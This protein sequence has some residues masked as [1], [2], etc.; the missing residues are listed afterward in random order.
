MLRKNKRP[1]G[2]EEGRALSG[3]HRGPSSPPLPCRRPALDWPHRDS[4]GGHSS[5][6]QPVRVPWTSPQPTDGRDGSINTPA[7]LF[8][9]WCDSE[10]GPSVAPGA[11]QWDRGLV[12]HRG[13]RPPTP[14]YWLLCMPCSTPFSLADAPSNPFPNPCLRFCFWG[15]KLKNHPLS[16][17]CGRKI[18]RHINYRFVLTLMNKLASLG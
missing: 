12:A 9:G 11:S 17:V 15:S 3:L 13:D 14:L 4:A 5:C 8:F 16:V 10:A 7:P 18:Y 1:F 2:L 6:A